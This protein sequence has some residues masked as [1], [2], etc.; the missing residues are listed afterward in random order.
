MLLELAI[1]YYVW[2]NY[3]NRNMTVAFWRRG[4]WLIAGE[5]LVLSMVL[6]RL[7]GG[8]K[9]GIYKYWGLV[10]SHML[11]I[12]GVN[13]F[14]YVQVVLFDKKMHNPTALLALTVVDF[15]LVLIWALVFKKLYAALFP[16]RRPFTGIWKNTHVSSCEPD[17]YPR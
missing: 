15:A 16:K 2:M 17:R 4:N 12:V 7:Y 8:L 13:A 3:Y 1:Y 14:S 5:Y 9:V 11:S 10:Y 6:H